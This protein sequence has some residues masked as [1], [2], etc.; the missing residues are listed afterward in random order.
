M[1]P[2]QI[3]GPAAAAAT[4]GEGGGQDMGGWATPR[5]GAAQLGG[6]DIDGFLDAL[7]DGVSA[8]SSLEAV[9]ELTTLVKAH[10]DAAARALCDAGGLEALAG[11]LAR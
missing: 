9:A 5:P 11:A 7:E 2:P 8:Q 3:E 1:G 6:T 10:G 4:G